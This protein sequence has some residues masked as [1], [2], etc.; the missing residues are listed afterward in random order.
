MAMAQTSSV[1]PNTAVRQFWERQPCGTQRAVTKDSQP[2]SAEWYER[3]ENHRYQVEPFIHSVAQFTRYNGKRVLEVGVGAGTDH[4]QW[5]RAGAEC[6]GVDLTDA[7]IITTQGRLALHG[8]RSNLQRMDA[9]KLPFPDDSFDV[10]YSWGVIHHSEH[11]AAIMDEVSRVLRPGGTF[12]GMLYGR[13]SPAVLK[14]WV[15]HA[16]LRGRPWRTFADVTYNHVESLGTKAYT[17]AEVRA[18][19]TGFGEVELTRLITPYE[20]QSVPKGHQSILSRRLG[21]EHLLSR[22]SVKVALASLRQSSGCTRPTIQLTEERHAHSS[23]RRCSTKFHESRSRDR[24]IQGARR[25]S[26]ARPHRSAL[27]RLHVG[28]L[29][30]AARNS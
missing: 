1:L 15:K 24:C 25:P 9:E 6:F 5:A 7:A 23:R 28:H 10:V 18:L 19:L 12:I 2:R 20:T 30:S 22:H 4:L 17:L 27:R 26:D 14:K 16:L 21:L 13:Y 8:L 29:L 3:V 11:P